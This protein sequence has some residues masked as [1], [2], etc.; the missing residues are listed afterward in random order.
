MEKR[1]E[2][3]QLAEKLER[4]IYELKENIEIARKMGLIV[5]LNI[6]SEVTQIRLLLKREDNILDTGILGIF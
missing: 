6:D 5:K 1:N 3:K 4:T 2:Y